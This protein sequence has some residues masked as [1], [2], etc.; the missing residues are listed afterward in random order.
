MKIEFSIQGR[1]PKPYLVIFERKGNHLNAMCSCPAGKN[2]QYCKHRLG[3]LAGDVTNL[4]S[5][6][7]SDVSKLPD[8][9]KDSDVQTAM[10]HLQQAEN[11]YDV[12]R[13]MMDEKLR[14]FKEEVDNRK[15][16]LARIMTQRERNS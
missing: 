15:Q 5:N 6:N 7:A 3:L 10:E 2:G 11:E 4:V 1:E 9:L 14:P 8:M 12:T 16:A 13:K